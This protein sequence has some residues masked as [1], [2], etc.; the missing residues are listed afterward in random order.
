MGITL[1]LSA[2]VVKP[3]ERL[4][5]SLKK[6][7]TCILLMAPGYLSLAQAPLEKKLSLQVTQGT[8]GDALDQ[9]A[10]QTGLAISF[11]SRK[12]KLGQDLSYTARDKNL[13]D[14]LDDLNSL[15]GL[16]FSL[17][18]KQIIIKPA[19]LLTQGKGLHLVTLSGYI[20][21]EV[22]GEMLIGA[23]IYIDSLQQGAV[24]NAYGFYSI[25]IPKGEYT[26][27]C[28]FIGFEKQVKSLKLERN[29]SAG[30][31]LFAKPP[32]LDEVIVMAEPPRTVE[33]IQLSKTDLRPNTVAAMPALFGEMDVIKSLAN[34]PGIKFHSDGSTFF[35]VRGGDRDQNLILQD[36][37]PIYNPTHL[38]G[39]FSTIIPDATKSIEIYKGEV[40]ASYGG[41]LS[42]VIDIH[43]KNG[44][45]QDFEIWG[46]VGLISTKL[47]IEGPFKKGQSSYLLAGR[48]SRIQWIAKT[49]S[50]NLDKLQFS[51]LTG[52]VNFQLNENNNVY[53][54]FYLGSDQFFQSNSGISW[55][56]QAGT[57]RW[58]NLVNDKIFVNTTFYA[59]DY[60]YFFHTNVS[61]NEFWRSRIGNVSIKSD[62]SYFVNPE[63]II[64]FGLG[65]I[66]QNFNPGNYESP[67]ANNVPPVSV[68]NSTEFNLYG[69]HEMKL[70]SK[71]GLNYGLRFTSFNTIGEAFEF[72]FNDDHQPV[73]TLLF[74]Q[75]QKYSTY[76]TLEPRATLSYLFNQ[77]NSVKVSYARNAQNIHLI[78]NSISPFNS[79]EVWL[80]SSLNIKPQL[81]NQYTLGYFF[82]WPQMGLSLTSEIYF[83]R[84]LN[85]IDYEDH[86]N[87]LL[88]SALEGELR[89]GE[90]KAYGIEITAKK[91]EGRLR[92]WLGY[93]YARVKRRFTEINDG[94]T[95]NAFNDRPN[96][97]NLVM[98]Y[99]I[100]LRWN[101]GLNWNYTTGAPF[102]SPTS[103]YNFDGQEVPV[104]SRKNND[105][106]PDYHRLDLSATVKLNKT[107][108]HRYRH[109][110]TFS[111]YNVY[112]RTNPVFI[113]F[114]KVQTGKNEFATPGNLFL[115]NNTSSAMYIFKFM[116]S[117][118]YNFRFK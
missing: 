102:S 93:S 20:K 64:T 40:P 108:A 62:F 28:S 36:E 11:N 66:G 12:I 47:G 13:Q 23:T 88:N 38:L 85:Q 32:L 22:S 82:F 86:A 49:Q 91:E 24:S 4:P 59:S 105:R 19:K 68:K 74:K 60:E 101:I 17:V 29:I 84:M 26:L 21:E 117:I 53:A 95:Y 61:G 9:I 34:I 1:K 41:K 77:N 106:L 118:S 8:L 48:L 96:E 14:V 2:P 103:F 16:R 107:P 76:N 27:S 99:D 44:N 30:F 63:N 73:D 83:K 113:N 72:T 69:N 33:E 25:T 71:L 58:N 94:M 7:F 97:I 80:P 100:S 110:L 114:N 98:N 90:A 75:G 31:N 39:L 54:S 79:I 81:A 70:G 42:S 10:D 46:N 3:I 56:N 104:Y 6:L 52:K 43:T 78:S 116:P 111:V 5:A 89:F 15:T 115:R 112:G 18:E 37:A 35:Y 45:N 55:Q 67:N 65:I 87:T 50:P 51:D 109:G 57:I 92:G